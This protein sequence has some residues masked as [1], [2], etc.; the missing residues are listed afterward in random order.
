M[1]LM[2]RLV[3]SM[4]LWVGSLNPLVVDAVELNAVGQLIHSLCQKQVPCDIVGV[5]DL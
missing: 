4:S 3:L 2:L 5:S 1:I